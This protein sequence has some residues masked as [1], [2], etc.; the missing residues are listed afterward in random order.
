MTTLIVVEGVGYLVHDV[1]GM[2]KEAQDSIVQLDAHV[3]PIL[4]E[5][6]GTE[7]EIL[8]P[9]VAQLAS[10][11]GLNQPSDTKSSDSMILHS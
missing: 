5:T 7:I 11:G 4:F 2:L 8:E 9:V 3:V 10:Y 6:E 1:V